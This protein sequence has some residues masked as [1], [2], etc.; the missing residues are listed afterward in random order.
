MLRRHGPAMLSTALAVLTVVLLAVNAS[1][2]AVF[3]ALAA[4]V[5][6][7]AG[8]AGGSRRDA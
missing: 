8:A 6:A 3:S 7:F 2:A 1:H 5:L 4:I